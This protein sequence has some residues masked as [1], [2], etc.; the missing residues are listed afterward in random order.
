MSSVGYGPNLLGRDWLSIPLNGE[1]DDIHSP[2]VYPLPRIED[3]YIL[4]ALLG[5]S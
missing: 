3:I 5:G 2:F 4:A 1:V